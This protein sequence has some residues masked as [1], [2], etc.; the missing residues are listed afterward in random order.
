MIN[1]FVSPTVSKTERV[2]VE[3]HESR[4]LNSTANEISSSLLGLQ[5]RSKVEFL[6]NTESIRLPRF[7]IAA[8]QL[9]LTLLEEER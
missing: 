6:Q 4:W 5:V 9:L 7:I 3:K 2:V 8:G 1:Y